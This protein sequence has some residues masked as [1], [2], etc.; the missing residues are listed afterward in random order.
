MKYLKRFENIDLDPYGEEDWDN[1]ILK[2]WKST[3]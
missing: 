1:V 2:V 3:I